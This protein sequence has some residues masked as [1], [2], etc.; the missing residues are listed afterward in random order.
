MDGLKTP[1]LEAFLWPGMTKV[2]PSFWDQ[3]KFLA[4]MRGCV[5]ERKCS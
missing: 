1:I 3:T 4:P 5:V 2:E